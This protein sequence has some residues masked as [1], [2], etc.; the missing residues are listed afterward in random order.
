MQSLAGTM[1]KLIE[2]RA[3]DEE[4]RKLLP[5]GPQPA[6][7][8]IF[9]ADRMLGAVAD[10]RASLPLDAASRFFCCIHRELSLRWRGTRHAD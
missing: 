10:M 5:L 2:V 9:E 7:F 4:G 3:Y 8:T 1:W 6:G